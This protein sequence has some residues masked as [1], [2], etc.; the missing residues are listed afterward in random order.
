MRSRRRNATCSTMSFSRVPAGPMAPGSSPP[1]PGVERD[2]DDAVGAAC[3]GTAARDRRWQR[4]RARGAAAGGLGGRRGGR[5]LS[6]IAGRGDRAAAS[7]APADRPVA[8][9]RRG[10]RRAG[11]GAGAGATAPGAGRGAGTLGGATAR[12]A[13]ARRRVPGRG[14][15]VAGRGTAGALATE[16]SLPPLVR[17]ASRRRSVISASIGSMAFSG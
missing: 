13:A 6:A 10:R 9:G 12:G 11:D 1:W 4:S 3:G 16:V 8:G 7:T 15:T 2:D 17:G 14:G 5:Q